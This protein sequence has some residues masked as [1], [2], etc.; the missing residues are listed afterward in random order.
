MTNQS[1]IFDEKPRYVIDTNVIVSFMHHTDDEVYGSDVFKPQWEYIESL[2]GSG[3]ITAPKKVEEELKKW[4]IEIPELVNWLKRYDSMFLDVTTDQLLKS[5]PIVS[6]YSV[7]GTTENYLCDLMVMSLAECMGLAVL[8]LEGKK[9]T[10][11]QKRPKIP[12]VCDEFGVDCYSVT[13]FL[14][15]ENFGNK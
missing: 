9:P 13:S 11:S 15:K 6:K 7:Y 10:N 8:T 4:C 2:V 1:S 3:A 5:K 14:R 12:N